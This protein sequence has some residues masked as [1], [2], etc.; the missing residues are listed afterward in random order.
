MPVE[1]ERKPKLNA[2]I[3]TFVPPYSLEKDFPKANQMLTDVLE[4]TDGQLNYVADMSDIEVDFATLVE[5]LRVA[6]KT[7][8]SAFSNPR[9]NMMTVMKSEVLKMGATAASQQEQYG[10]IPVQMFDSVDDALAHIKANQ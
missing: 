8:N 7:P 4:E 6:F 10:K 9:L 3:V 2:I 1:F 5:G